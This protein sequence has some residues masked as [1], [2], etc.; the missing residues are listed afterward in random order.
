MKKKPPFVK[1][2][3]RRCQKETVLLNVP[4]YGLLCGSCVE[5]YIDKVLFSADSIDVDQKKDD[6]FRDKLYNE[7]EQNND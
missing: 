4:Y 7:S 1:E 6:L 5:Q 2:K 3:C